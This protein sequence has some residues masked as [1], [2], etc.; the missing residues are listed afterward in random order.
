MRV[1]KCVRTYVN[2]VHGSGHIKYTGAA[3]LWDITPS[4]L[5]PPIVIPIEGK[6]STFQ[7]LKK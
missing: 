2:C 3:I 5:I 4:I 1:T 7:N 6:K